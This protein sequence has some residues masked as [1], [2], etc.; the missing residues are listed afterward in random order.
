MVG[1]AVDTAVPSS[2]ERNNETQMDRKMHQNVRPLR[3]FTSVTVDMLGLDSLFEDMGRMEW[4]R[5]G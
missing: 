4:A 1:R 5:K 2:A 3:D